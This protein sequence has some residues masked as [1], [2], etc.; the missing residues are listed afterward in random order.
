M[1]HP[2]PALMLTACF[3]PTPSNHPCSHLQHTLS[4]PTFGS[5]P[6]L[7]GAGPGNA[8]EHAFL[9]AEP[10]PMLSAMISGPRNRC[11][12]LPSL[13]VNSFGRELS[14]SKY[15]DHAERGRW[16]GLEQVVK[17]R[18]MCEDCCLPS[19]QT[20]FSTTSQLSAHLTGVLARRITTLILTQ[21]A[22]KRCSTGRTRQDQVFRCFCLDL[23]ASSKLFCTCAAMQGMNSEH[24]GVKGS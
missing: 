23:S 18:A 24:T 10:Y 8:S 6:V 15:A 12:L 13:M 4:P 3:S 16:G 1:C 5:Q 7:E 21:T 2:N 14:R 11:A 17:N 9:L 22:Q 20:V 19:I